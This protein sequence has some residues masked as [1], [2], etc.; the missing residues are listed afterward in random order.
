VIIASWW[1]L[2]STHTLLSISAALAQCCRDS[3][4]GSPDGERR[5]LKGSFRVESSNQ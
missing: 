2:V 5:R 1:K 4:R 3:P